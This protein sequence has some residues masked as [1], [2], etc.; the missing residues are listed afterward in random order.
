M[1]LGWWDRTVDGQMG[2]GGWVV[3]LLTPLL[4]VPVGSLT[5]RGLFSHLPALTS[6][7]FGWN[8]V[9]PGAHWSSLCS[10]QGHAAAPP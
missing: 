2:A 3:P 1:S 8:S 9:A 5:S 10:G 6:R 4:D 7:G